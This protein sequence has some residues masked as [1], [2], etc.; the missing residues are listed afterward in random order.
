MR[1]KTGLPGR[2]P[3]KLKA[4]V[5][6]L[7]A[8]FAISAV[9]ASSATAAQGDSFE[10]EFNHVGLFVSI[11]ALGELDELVLDPDTADGDDNLLGSLKFKGT[12]TDNA[13]NFNVPKATGLDFPK[14]ALNIEGVNIDGE[15][16]LAEDGTG[17][18]DASTGKLD[19][20][21]KLALILGADEIGS[22]GL[23]IP[24][25]GALRCE[26]APL[27]IAFSSDNG[28]PHAGQRYTDKAG[29][30]EGAIAGAFT[31][32]PGAKSLIEENASL[33]E[34][35][36]GMLDPVGGI[37]LGN[38]SSTLAEMPAPTS[39]KPPETKCPA[40][41]TGNYPDCQPIPK[42]ECAPGETGTP[43]DCVKPPKQL[44]PG[45]VGKVTVTPKRAKVKRGKVVRLRIRVTNTGQ[46]N[47]KTKVRIKSSNK[48]VKAPKVVAFNVRPGKAQVKVIRVKAAKKAKGKARIIATAAKKRGVAVLTVR[49]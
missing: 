12:Y 36:G 9:S 25:S 11:G 13:G 31:Y 38:F 28:W 4:A 33:C 45:K 1:E 37:W 44:R 22:I 18:Y 15:I 49:R 43:P 7:L 35:L 39:P 5:L 29:L 10:A 2:V 42:E 32:R 27:D 8:I 21:V 20:N 48:R 26:F 47:L 14:L 40:D 17:T 30:E 16:K 23:P 6:A 19:L 34:L 24:A 41:T 3:T 46:K